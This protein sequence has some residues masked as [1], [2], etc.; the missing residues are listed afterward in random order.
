M[1]LLT[2]INHNTRLTI[3][4][5]SYVINNNFYLHYENIWTSHKNQNFVQYGRQT[6]QI[7]SARLTVPSITTAAH[8]YHCNLE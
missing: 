5:C 3:N 6:F 4:K 2:I 7:D 8:D 1:V